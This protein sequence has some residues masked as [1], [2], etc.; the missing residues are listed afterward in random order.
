MAKHYYKYNFM[1]CGSIVMPQLCHIFVNEKEG[2]R[3]GVEI[4]YITYVLGFL[5]F[6]QIKYLH[7]KTQASIS[8]SSSKII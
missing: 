8:M 6:L 3:G 4:L 2:P 1:F 7:H 5:F